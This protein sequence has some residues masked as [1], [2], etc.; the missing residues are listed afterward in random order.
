MGVRI[1]GSDGATK[2]LEA[3]RV[4]R[5][6]YGGSQRTLDGGKVTLDSLQAWNGS[7]AHNMD[8][9]TVEIVYKAYKPATKRQKKE[10]AAS[11]AAGVHLRK[12]EGRLIDLRENEDGTTLVL[13][14]TGLRTNS[15]GVEEPCF[16]AMNIQKGAVLGIAI[17]DSL[18]QTAEAIEALDAANNGAPPKNSGANASPRHNQV[19]QAVGEDDDLGDLTNMDAGNEFDNAVEVSDRD[20]SIEDAHDEANRIQT[21]GRVTVKA[22]EGKV[23]NADSLEEL[24]KNLTKLNKELSQGGMHKKVQGLVHKEVKRQL[25]VVINGLQDI[26]ANMKDPSRP[27]PELSADQLA[28]L[29]GWEG[30]DEEAEE[31]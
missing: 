4:E 21:A 11:K 3:L 31:Y 24:G 19:T 17:D 20:Q 15:A 1:I 13:V 29:G 22:T 28:K 25:S 16:R 5:D 7:S 18:G 10:A 12:M 2:Y 9:S 23:V 8:G 14:T 30:I 26:V 6:A 27:M